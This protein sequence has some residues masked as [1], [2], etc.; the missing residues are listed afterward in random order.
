MIVLITG[1]SSGIG[2]ATAVRLGAAGH[3]VFAGRLDGPSAAAPPGVCELPLDVRSDESVAAFVETARAR[4]GRI[5]ALVNNAAYALCGAIEETTLAEAK[6]VLDT[7]FFGAVRL[8]RALVPHFRAQGGGR[9]VN[10]S[11]GAGFTAEPFAGW[12]T[13][14]KFAVEGFSETLWHELRPFGVQVSLVQSGW[15]RTNIVRDAVFTTEP[16][17]DYDP[18]RR[19]CIDTA[20]RSLEA[21]MPPDH[22]ARCVQRALEARRPRLRYRVGADVTSSFWAR[23]FMPAGVFHWLVHRHYRLHRP[24]LP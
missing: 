9:I 24:R 15:C 17:A 6:Q 23:R 21:G 4:G 2:Q 13:V 7:N 12:Y 20:S 8:V 18:W 1:T 16:V 5:D 19:V 22:V 14:S 10:I 3:T 11:S